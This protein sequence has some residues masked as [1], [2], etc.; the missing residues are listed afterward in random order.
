MRT[1]SDNTALT[2][3]CRDGWWPY[4]PGKGP[5]LEA[6][7]W[8]AIACRKNLQLA[9]ATLAYLTGA[10]NKD[11]GWSTDFYSGRSDWTSALAL[12]AQ[13]ILLKEINAAEPDQNS[14]LT[15]EVSRSFE[16]GV[17]FLSGARSEL[18]NNVSKVILMIWKGPDYDYPRGWPW[19]PDTFHWVEPTSYALLALKPT[20]WAWQKPHQQI[21]RQ[22]VAYLLQ[23]SCAGGGWNYGC[24]TVLGVNLEPI[25]MTTCVALLSLQDEPLCPVIESS[26]SYLKGIQPETKTLLP[27]AWSTLA[28]HS[29]GE[30]VAPL[31]RELHSRRNSDGGFGDNLTISALATI[32]VDI[33]RMD[34]PLKLK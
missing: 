9:K 18:Y 5:S 33:P 14:T 16:S 19:T 24:T 8:C 6:T 10:Q 32:A 11:G 7:A 15:L 1:K 2:E 34:N 12:L 21:I 20:D 26:L 4:T 13:R 30:D 29:L 3:H 27:L 31:L 17:T 22:A 28:L 25:P 23:K